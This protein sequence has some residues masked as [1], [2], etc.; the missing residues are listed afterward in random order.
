MTDYKKDY[1]YLVEEKENITRC[2]HTLGVIKEAVALAKKY[3]INEDK[4][5]I[6]ASL[7]DIT[8]NVPIDVQKEEI[9]KKL[10]PNV[11]SDLPMGAYHA[12]SGYL[13]AKDVLQIDDEDILNAINNHTLGRPKMSPLEKIIFISDFIEPSRNS[14]ESNNAKALA[15]LNLDQCLVYIMTYT[16]ERNQAIGNA[17][18]KIAFDA[19]EYYKGVMGE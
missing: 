14:T 5:R 13:Y 8:K 6:A 1:L 10:G 16:I 17:V 12:I 2:N 18:P 9:I 15:Y 3:G 19:L 4:A 11:L 7:H